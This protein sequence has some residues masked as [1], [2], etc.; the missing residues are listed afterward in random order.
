MSR[1][2]KKSFK[3]QVQEM[4]GEWTDGLNTLSVEE[5]DKMIL[6]YAKHREEVKED[7]KNNE[8]LNELAELKKELEAPYRDSLKAIDIK[9]RYL[10]T[11]LAEKGGDATGSIKQ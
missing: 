7:R 1:K 2:E 3:E 11:L 6:R 4:Y 9:T 10:L 5:L 8:R